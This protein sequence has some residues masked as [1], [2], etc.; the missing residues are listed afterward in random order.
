MLLSSYFRLGSFSIYLYK[1]SFFGSGLWRGLR[2]RLL[3]LRGCL[4]YWK[5]DVLKRGHLLAACAHGIS[6]SS[7]AIGGGSSLFRSRL[8][9][10]LLLQAAGMRKLLLR[11]ARM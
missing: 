1:R 3:A 6:C 11:A 8:R 2:R 7:F 10:G 9:S 4:P 5:A